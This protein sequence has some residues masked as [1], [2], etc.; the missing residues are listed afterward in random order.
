MLMLITLV[1]QGL[2][3]D[4]HQILDVFCTM[5]ETRFEHNYT[6]LIILKVLIS[7]SSV[8]Y[9]GRILAQHLFPS[10]NVSIQTFNHPLPANATESLQKNTNFFVQGIILCIQTCTGACLIFGAFAELPIKVCLN[11][12]L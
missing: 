1:P 2:I 7:K 3:L 9:S 8:L 10:K 6:L 5:T 4:C 12:S 11:N